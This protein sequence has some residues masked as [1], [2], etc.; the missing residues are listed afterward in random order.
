MRVIAGT[1][2]GH[3]LQQPAA[4]TTR[5]T[6]DRVKE[7]LMSALESRR[8]LAG[9]RV[10]D[11]FAGSGALGI[12]AASRGAAQVLLCETDGKAL[13]VLKANIAS[14]PGAAKI[15]RARRLDVV[16]NPPLGSGPFDI[17]FLDPPYAFRPEQIAAFVEAL[18][19]GGALA[20]GALVHYEHAK[21]DTEAAH[22]AFEQLQ[23]EALTTKRYGD[24]AFDLL[25]RIEP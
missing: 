9:T 5:P 7:A 25:Q 16:K 23:W 20:P 8:E 4:S 22:A 11:A 14:L 24:I 13:S 1:W 21:K 19:T 12:E 17:V 3:R 2:R 10:L 6:T 18:H 15:V